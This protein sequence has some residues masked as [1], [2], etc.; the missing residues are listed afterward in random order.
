M[1][2]GMASE[3]KRHY[4][5]AEFFCGCGGSSH[6]FQRTGR[7]NVVFG[8]DIKPEALRTFELNHGN[9]GV[10]AGVLPGD[11]RKL[12]I[13]DINAKLLRAGVGAGELDCLIG[14]PPCQGFSQMRRSEERKPGEIV[15][16]KG[17]DRL[18]HDPRNDLV[19][20]FL[21]I[22]GFLNPKVILIEN[23]PQ[24]LRHGHN[25][26]AGGL[27]E[28]VI[29]LLREMGYD[30][31]VDTV[32]AAD[33]G[34]PQL[35]ERAIFL[36]SRVGKID[37]PAIT[38]ADPETSEAP[39]RPLPRWRT[40]RDA[41]DDLPLE[42]PVGHDE[43][44]GGSLALYRQGEISEYARLMRAV[45]HFPYNHITR[46]Y[47]DT[48]LSIVRCMKAGETWD[49]ASSR[50]QSKYKKVIAKYQRQRESDEHAIE[51]LS[52]EG[53]LNASFFRSYYWSA[54]TRLA[55]DRP[56][57]TITANANFLGSGRFTHPDA[58]RG[59]T[60]RE[61]ARLQSF[62]DDFRFI[63][64]AKDDSHTTKIGIGLDMIGEAVPPLL[65]EAFARQIAMALDAHHAQR[66]EVKVR[67]TKK[68]GVT[69]AK[70]C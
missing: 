27:A 26:K 21:E 70:A 29:L 37:F 51:R 11:I 30:T 23:V 42:P 16:F 6:G 4:T 2:V 68:P 55:W 49:D 50:M 10:P 63:T 46:K 31:V 56:A 32:N 33:Y 40:V 66:G 67:K 39:Q 41:M 36:A 8:N 20:R 65:G 47:S 22:A 28:S 35:R 1:T 15:R 17:Y 62:D 7:F 12:S 18:A 57:L 52:K 5:V 45:D 24:M 59:I 69:T 44:G 64:N 43:L 3:P 54:Y 14:G 58:E 19:L 34:V 61:A 48:V 13:D 60:M 38:H 53:L 9:N 25:G